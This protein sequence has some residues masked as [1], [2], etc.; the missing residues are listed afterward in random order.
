VAVELVGKHVDSTVNNPAEA[1]SHWKK[2]R[3]GSGDDRF[4]RID[5]PG[6]E[7]HPTMKEATGKDMSYLMLRGIFMAP[8]HQGTGG[9]LCPDAE[10]GVGNPEWKK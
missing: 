8:G 1:V 3:C 5:L 7:G 4:Q 2:G 9:L 10:E 6:L